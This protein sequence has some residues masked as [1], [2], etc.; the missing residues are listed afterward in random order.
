MIGK[1]RLREIEPAAAGLKALYSPKTAIIDFSKV[2]QAYANVIK[3]LG[4]EI[5]LSQEVKQ[6][7]YSNTHFILN[8]KKVTITTKFLINCAG[9]H[10][11]KIANM[12]DRAVSAK[13]IIPF[14]GEYYDLVHEKI[15]LINGLIYPVNGKM[16][17][18]FAIVQKKGMVH[19]LNAPSPGA[20]APF[21]IGKHIASLYNQ[22]V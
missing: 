20:M 22:M 13:Q 2:V 3:S 14:Q 6:I 7:E 15:S 1:K 4:G 12:I 10:A 9:V 17:D 5:L 11:D 18:D 16:C 8:T 19:V 21:S